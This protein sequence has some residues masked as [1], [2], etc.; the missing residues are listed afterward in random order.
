MTDPQPINPS[1]KNLTGFLDKSRSTHKSACAL[2][3]M[4]RDQYCD[5]GTK[6][7]LPHHHV[8]ACGYIKFFNDAAKMEY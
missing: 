5:C 4:W 8:A 2:M 3:R 1:L 7:I 6:S